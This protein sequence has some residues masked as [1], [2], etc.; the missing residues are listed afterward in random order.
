[1]LAH[2]LELRDRLVK[3]TLTIL[4]VFAALFAFRNDIWAII[5]KPLLRYIPTLITTEVAGTFLVPVKLTL[6]LSVFIAIPVVL[7]HLWAFVAPG[8]YKDER[9]M[10][11]PLL[12]SS[13]L[14]FFAG[15]AFAYFLV[16]PLVFK[17][18]ASVAP[19]GVAVMT[20]INKYLDFVLSLFFAFGVA[21]EVPVAVI[22][23]VWTGIVTPD[24][25]VAQRRYIIVMAFVVA[26]LLTPPDVTS[27]ILLAVPLCLLFEI[28][29]MVSRLYVRKKEPEDVV[30]EEP[31]PVSQRVYATPQGA[32]PVSQ[33]PYAIAR[34]P[35]SPAEPQAPLEK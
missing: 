16:F 6:I 25:L 11:Y 14:L 2:L 29:V 4:V 7:Y 20:D 3:V 18:F 24:K 28:G 15:A 21:F 10:I 35:E 27:Q 23:L 31:P 33:M 26:M 12:I 32:Q 9:K 17:F 22:L 8:L 34:G 13:T 5:S 30:E 19:D 1:M